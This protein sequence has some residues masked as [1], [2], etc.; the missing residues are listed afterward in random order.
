M[1]S[2]WERDAFLNY[3][4]IVVGG[5]IVGLSTAVS[6]KEQSPL[7]NVLV[8]ESGVFPS[9]ASTKN[10][11]FSCFGSLS[12][13]VSD[14]EAMHKE[15][16]ID[17]ID[18][19]WKGLQ[20]LQ[21]RLGADE[22]DFQQYGGYELLDKDQ[23][24]VLEHLD[25]VNDL[26]FPLF[27]Q[28]VYEPVPSK[29]RDFGFSE[30]RVRNMIFNPFEGQIHTGKMMKRLQRY[31]TELGVELLKG[32]RVARI[33]EASKSVTVEL[34]ND[35]I[36]LKAKAVA[37]CT[38]AFAKDLIPDLP[39]SPGRGLVLITKPIKDLPFQGT[40]HYDDGYYYFRNYQ[41]RVLFGGGRNLAKYEEET[42]QFGINDT[43]LKRLKTD[44]KEMILPNR[45]FEIDQL[46]SGIMAFGNNK[47]PILKKHSK[48][49]FLGVRLG[50]M[51]V[52]IGS[53]LG[54]KLSQMMLETE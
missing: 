16:V 47:Q 15:E 12:E 48:R 28:K 32:A 8:L 4:V 6:I 23:V 40:F 52:A 37:I 38:N 14:L 26:L 29:I 36:H 19:R 34:E 50:G 44:L 22:I 27:G 7:K 30:E 13:V 1:L 11:G 35:N 20:L 9:G 42:T 10:A 39:L 31:A 46:W 51:G 18:I 33:E 2:F 43:I 21:E 5:G 25:Q 41:D 49:I 17:L 53:Q 3:D 45:A 54:L 24:S